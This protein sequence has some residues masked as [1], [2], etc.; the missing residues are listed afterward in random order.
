MRLKE[1]RLKNF[2]GYKNETTVDFSDLTVFVGRND[3]GKSTVLEAI[4]IFLNQGNGAVKLD[5]GDIN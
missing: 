2:R 4:D 5:K 3:K 1:L